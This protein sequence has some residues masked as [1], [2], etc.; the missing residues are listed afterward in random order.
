VE[1][2]TKVGEGAGKQTLI[3]PAQALDA[4]SD[5]FKMLKGRG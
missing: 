3:V 1:A 4:F 2:L 5:A